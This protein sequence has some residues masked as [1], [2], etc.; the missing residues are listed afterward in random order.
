MIRL[1]TADGRV[2]TRDLRE[3]ACGWCA[4]GEEGEE[5]EWLLVNRRRLERDG[6]GDEIRQQNPL[7]VDNRGVQHSGPRQQAC[8]QDGEDEE[9][10]QRP[11]RSSHKRIESIVA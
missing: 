9:A 5:C 8:Q 11:R 1:S 10:N 3:R 6:D 2:D 7:R 4:R